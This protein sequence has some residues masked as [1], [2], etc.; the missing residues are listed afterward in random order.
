M[1][2]NRHQ[3]PRLRLGL[4]F[5]IQ[6]TLRLRRRQIL[7]QVN[8]QMTIH[9]IGRCNPKKTHNSPEM[10]AMVDVPGMACLYMLSKRRVD[11]P[12]SACQ[13]R[14]QTLR[15]LRGIFCHGY[16][17]FLASLKWAAPTPSSLRLR[18]LS[19]F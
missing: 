4:L 9:L 15:G 14:L 12:V 8:L 2:H 3:L 5:T 17:R 6:M 16:H 1:A 7:R 19:R 11:Q 13:G 10:K 18:R